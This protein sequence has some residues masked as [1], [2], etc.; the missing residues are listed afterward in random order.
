MVDEMA[1]TAKAQRKAQSLWITSLADSK[2]KREEARQQGILVVER[3]WA[4]ATS[5][6]KANDRKH[7]LQTIDKQIRLARLQRGLE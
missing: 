1:S 4:Q 3:K 7:E 5:E 6:E 2:G